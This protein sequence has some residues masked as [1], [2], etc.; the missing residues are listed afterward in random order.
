MDKNKK[1]ILSPFVVSTLIDSMADKAKYAYAEEQCEDYI[2]EFV[3]RN[4]DMN[5][6]PELQESI[7]KVQYF[8]L[9]ERYKRKFEG[10]TGCMNPRT[11][12][13][14]FFYKLYKDGEL[15][16]YSS[17]NINEINE[18][19][20]KRI[21][22]YVTENI[23]SIRKSFDESLDKYKYLVIK[24]FFKRKGQ[25][26]KLRLSSA[27]EKTQKYLRKIKGD[28]SINNETSEKIVDNSSKPSTKNNKKVRNNSIEDDDVRL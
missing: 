24:R 13:S 6:Y 2:E 19:I 7:S 27:N 5:E 9:E 10:A 15:P 11:T 23:N 28:K 1:F 20:M 14:N 21:N 18:R 3:K 12:Y 17:F 26:F 25:A 22:S 8:I 16:T 4:I